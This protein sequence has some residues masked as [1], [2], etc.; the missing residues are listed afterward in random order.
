MTK[1]WTKSSKCE[2]EEEITGKGGGEIPSTG[3]M[4]AKPGTSSGVYDEVYIIKN[5]KW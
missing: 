1:F 5:L 4:P 3:Q 2:L